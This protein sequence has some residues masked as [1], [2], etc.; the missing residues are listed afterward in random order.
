[1]TQDQIR[2]PNPTSR[3]GSDTPTALQQNMRDTAKVREYRGVFAN[4]LVQGI[5]LSVI[6]DT[7]A[8]RNCPKAD[9]SN[10]IADKVGIQAASNGGR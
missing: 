6:E 8:G 7:P 1:M 3:H 10:M 2:I 9:L 4:L 5:V